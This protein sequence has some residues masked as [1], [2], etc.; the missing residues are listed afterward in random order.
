MIYHLIRN[1]E[2]ERETV[3]SD[4]DAEYLRTVADDLREM[5]FSGDSTFYTIEID[6]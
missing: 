2:G 6:F 1:A 4:Y 5:T 3:M